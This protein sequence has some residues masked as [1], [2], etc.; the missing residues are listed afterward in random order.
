MAATATSFGMHLSQ[1]GV[2]GGEEE[3][4]KEFRPNDQRAEVGW[5]CIVQALI[6]KYGDTHPYT[7]T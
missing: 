4:A 7:E 6:E 1:C 3:S 5:K 2:E